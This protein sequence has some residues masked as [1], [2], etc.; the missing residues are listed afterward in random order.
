[1]D[2]EEFISYMVFIIANDVIISM[3]ALIFQL[4][5]AV[6]SYQILLKVCLCIGELFSA[7]RWGSISYV[8]EPWIRPSRVFT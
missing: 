2:V 3:N 1:M 7:G 8:D 5:K 6:I 4:Y